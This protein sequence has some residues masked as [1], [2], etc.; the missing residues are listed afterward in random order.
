M[1]ALFRCELGSVSHRTEEVHAA[2]ERDGA[3]I[4][5]SC[6]GETMLAELRSL[7]DALPDHAR[8]RTRSGAS[9]AARNLLAMPSLRRLAEDSPLRELAELTLGARA[10]PIRGL[11]FDK[12][13][14]ANWT[15]PWHQDLTIA[16]ARRSDAPGFGPWSV[17]AGVVHV[18]APA[19]VLERCLACRVHL[20]PSTRSNG[21]LEVALESH[22]DGLLTRSEI[23][24]RTRGRSVAACSAHPGD[25]LIMRPLLLHRSLP[26][27]EPSRRRTV[28]FEYSSAELP[29][30]LDWAH[31]T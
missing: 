8:R 14:G 26:G 18:Q 9:Y 19:S 22:R 6:F 20:D 23:Q 3:A 1:A 24:P 4:I 16:V 11:L 21:G 10:L 12:R 29:P 27:A 15:V 13:P 2:I 25:V 31:A 30:G 28:H 5:E 17:K 7:V